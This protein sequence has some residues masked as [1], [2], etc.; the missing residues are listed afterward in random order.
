MQV[1]IGQVNVMGARA[2][3]LLSRSGFSGRVLAVVSNA[4]YLVGT[5]QEVIWLARVGRV[6]IHPRGV[7]GAFDF[8][9]LCAGMSFRCRDTQ[10]QFDA[11]AWVDLT[12]PR[13]WQP[14][15]ILNIAPVEIVNARVGQLLAALES[16][17][18][19]ESLAQALPLVSKRA[20]F[21][22]RRRPVSRAGWS[23]FH[24]PGPAFVAAALDSIDELVRACRAGDIA[25]VFHYARAL[26]GLGPGLTPSG[27]DFVGGLFFA[28]YHLNEAYP[29]TFHWQPQTV[30]TW[31][32]GAR[33]QTNL[34]S[35]TLLR[36]HARGE[37]AA[38]LHDLIGALLQ[39]REVEVCLASA[40]R[41]SEIGSTSG[42]DI[43]AGILTALLCWPA[44]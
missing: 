20:G 9:K 40:R 32:D 13:L 2:R 25:A 35:Y 29:G 39:G 3:E 42:W 44:K 24:S 23:E 31:L 19:G 11:G 16:S 18:C 28:T 27:D 36:D 17:D 10:L 15:H 12:R 5:G 8:G 41:V 26:I 1:D 43:L 33:A 30:E 7:L 22:N 6:P 21:E 4:T 37:G 14:V 38:P 34:I